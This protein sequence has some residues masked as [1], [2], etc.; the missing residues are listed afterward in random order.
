[1][2]QNPDAVLIAIMVAAAFP[3]LLIDRESNV[4]TIH[5]GMNTGQHFTIT[6]QP[7]YSRPTDALPEIQP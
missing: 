3:E 1:M 2:A 7:A 4:V 5:D 6:V